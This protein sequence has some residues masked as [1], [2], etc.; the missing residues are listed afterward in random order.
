MRGVGRSPTAEERDDL[1]RYARKHGL[2]KACRVLFNANEFVF[3][4]G[5]P[6]DYRDRIEYVP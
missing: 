1:I 4:A 2:A 6:M 5:D 3:I